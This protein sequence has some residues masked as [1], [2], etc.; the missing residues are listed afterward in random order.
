ME[1]RSFKLTNLRAVEEDGQVKIVGYAAVFNVLSED[2]GYFREQI[3]PGAF[4]KTIKEADIR[5]L[6][7]HDS[8]FVLGRNRANT[9]TLTEDQKGLLVVIN[10]P[11]TQW[12]RDLLESI[13]RGDIT[14]MSFGFRIIKE[15]WDNEK[16]IATLIEVKLYDV[17]VVT[18]PAYP[19][20]DVGLMSNELY[21]LGMNQRRGIPITK[22]ENEFI[23]SLRTRFKFEPEQTLHSEEP[24]DNLDHSPEEPGQ[25][26]RSDE[27]YMDAQKRRLEL[28]AF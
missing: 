3:R 7:N 28:I 4:T 13:N 20:T 27:I 1:R 6:L 16:D 23:N 10:P 21:K 17:S 24:P 5:A 8:N 11:D 2:L 12:A 14:Q 15:E 19:Q 22:E 18:F 9:L 26:S 25:M